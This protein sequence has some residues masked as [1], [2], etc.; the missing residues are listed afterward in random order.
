[1]EYIEETIVEGNGGGSMQQLEI[2]L[3]STGKYHS[4]ARDHSIVFLRQLTQ[5]VFEGCSESNASYY[6]QPTKS[7]ADVCAVA[8]K[9]EPFVNILLHFLAM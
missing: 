9:L 4:H 5:H 3:H 7:E 6:S 8:E 1:M 2:S